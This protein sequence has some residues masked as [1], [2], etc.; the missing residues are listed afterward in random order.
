MGERMSRA[1]TLARPLPGSPAHLGDVLYL[2]G[3]ETARGSRGRPPLR[4]QRG[5]RGLPVLISVDLDD[6]LCGRREEVDDDRNHYLAAE[7]CTLTRSLRTSLRPQC[8]KWLRQSG[9]LSLKR[10]QRTIL[11]THSCTCSS[12]GPHGFSP[13][14]HP[15]DPAWLSIVLQQIVPRHD[16]EVFEACLLQ[17]QPPSARG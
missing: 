4:L 15:R 9:T 13:Q 2:V 5:V 17:K 7:E 12:S 14:V 6:E 3:F 8:S 11:G 1:G 16:S 10:L